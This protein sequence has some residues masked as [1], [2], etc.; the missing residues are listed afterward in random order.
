VTKRKKG[1]TNRETDIEAERKQTEITE[2]QTEIT[3]KQTE[4]QRQKTE[5]RT[6]AS[7]KQH[8]R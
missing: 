3:E 2:K 7:D 5:G 4:R 8:L 1:H 6:N